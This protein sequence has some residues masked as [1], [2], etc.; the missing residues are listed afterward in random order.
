MSSLDRES[1]A[2]RQGLNSRIESFNDAAYPPGCASDCPTDPD[3]QLRSKFMNP[4]CG[5][6]MPLIGLAMRLDTL[7][8]LDDM[9]EL[10]RQVH[11]SIDNLVAEMNQL[12]YEPAQVSAYSYALCLFLDETVMRRPWGKHSLWSHRSMLGEFHGDTHGGEKIFT[13]LARMEQEPKRFKD[14]LEFIY[15]VLCMGLKG[16]YALAPDGDTALQAHITRLH[17]S[18]RELRGPLPALFQD[19]SNNVAPHKFRMR[20]S[21]PWWSPVLIAAGIIAALYGYYSWRLQLITGE[22]LD[23]LNRILQQ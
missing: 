8:K 12:R 16:K 9:A 7:D 2:A 14:V 19:A 18:I 1:V 15:L 6:A 13:L 20:R 5:A 4:M 21:W 3:F 23:S 10:H 11:I 22:V 17:K